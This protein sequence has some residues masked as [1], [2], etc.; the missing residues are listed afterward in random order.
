MMKTRT[1]TS[2]GLVALLCGPVACGGDD[3]DSNTSGAVSGTEDG[4]HDGGGGDGGDGDQGGGDHSGGTAEKP[5][6]NI[7]PTTGCTASPVTYRIG[8]EFQMPGQP[9][10]SCIILDFGAEGVD[11][12]EGQGAT[13]LQSEDDVKFLGAAS[14]P[15]ACADAQKTTPPKYSDTKSVSGTIK[16][17]AEALVFDVTVDLGAPHLIRINGEHTVDASKACAGS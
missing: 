3:E 14:V 5:T 12:I 7:A 16:G 6:Q 2:L 15:G 11:H 1:L 9:T 10:T 4:G 13:A 17:P 8:A